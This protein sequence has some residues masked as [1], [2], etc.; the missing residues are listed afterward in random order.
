MN[1]FNQMKTRET[2]KMKNACYHQLL[3][4][5]KA[6]IKK[7]HTQKHKKVCCTIDFVFASEIL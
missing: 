7:R 2:E 5:S 1:E 4:P 6:I 3:L